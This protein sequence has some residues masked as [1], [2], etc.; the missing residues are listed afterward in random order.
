MAGL[1]GFATHGLVDA[2]F[3]EFPSVF[4]IVIMLAVFALRPVAPRPTLARSDRWWLKPVLASALFVAG[5]GAAIWSDTGFV[6]FDRAVSASHRGDWAATVEALRTAVDRDPDYDYYR[7]Q[8][9]L[10]YGQLAADDHAFLPDAIAA[11]RSGGIDRDYYALNH[12]NLAWLLW[13][14]GEQDEAINEMSRAVQL[15]QVNYIYHLNLGFMLEQVGQPEAAHL[16]YAQAVVRAPRLLELSFWDEGRPA[17]RSRGRLVET[18]LA[19]AGT[20]QG[21]VSSSLTPGQAAYYLGDW[22][23][24][25]GWLEAS[26]RSSPDDPELWMDLGRVWLAQGDPARALDAAQRSV[27]LGAP[28]HT[29]FEISA[30]TYLALGD[31]EA[32]AADLRV[33]Y[34]LSPGHRTYMLLGQLAEAQ[35]DFERAADFY[36]AAI[37]TASSVRAVNYGPWVWARPPLSV[38]TVPFIRQPALAESLVEAYLRLGDLRARQGR[39]SEA[40]DAYEAVLGIDPDRAEAQSRL[41]ALP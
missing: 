13:E 7:L 21:G 12:A 4:L 34:F 9:G 40:R 17:V 28:L 39:G 24:A 37:G 32:A 23:K 16:E 26:L 38:D 19:L 27:A 20:S 22:E 30:E 29:A 10:A 6:A 11:Y 14:A 1:V 5:I 8:L 33:V 36:E 35:G 41:K 31:L 15:E 3:L 2:L 18:V 25:R